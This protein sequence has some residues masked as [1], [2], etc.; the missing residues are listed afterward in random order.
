MTKEE[1]AVKVKELC[2]EMLSHENFMH[3]LGCM[4]DD[5]EIACKK[6]IMKQLTNEEY[7]AYVKVRE[8]LCTAT[9]GQ[10]IEHLKANFKPTDKV[11]YMDCVQGYKN[12]CTYM[13]KD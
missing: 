13:T 11:C 12:D 8:A 5:C 7:E 9:V 1:L 2:P 4:L 10:A 3:D 6:K